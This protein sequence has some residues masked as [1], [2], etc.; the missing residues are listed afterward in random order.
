MSDKSQ[1]FYLPELDI[2]RCLA[3][4]AVFLFHAFRTRFVDY[5]AI[6]APFA[7][8]IAAVLDTGK[9]SVDLFFTLSAYLITELLIREQ[10]K[11]GEIDAK[12]FYLRRMLRIFPLYY[13]FIIFAIFVY[14]LFVPDA[15]IGKRHS[16]GLLTYTFN[17]IV[18][19]FG[20]PP[21]T[22]INHLWS[23]GVEEQFYLAFPFIVKLIGIKNLKYMALIF[24]CVGTVS[25]IIMINTDFF[26]SAEQAMWTSTLTR[27]DALAGGIL[28]AF[29][30]QEKKLFPLTGL[31]SK[32]AVIFFSITALALC[33]SYF[34]VESNVYNA[35][36]VYPA[37]TLAGVVIIWAAISPNLDFSKFSVLIY[38]GKISYG[39]YVFHLFGLMLAKNIL[40][41]SLKNNSS[42]VSIAVLGFALTLIF[43]IASYHL[44][45]K[46]FLKLKKR[47]TYVS[48]R[49]V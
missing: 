44:L 29:Y 49:P 25:R 2:V 17:W 43:A 21:R 41:V 42:A 27:L 38:L 13:V 12:S 31:F 34:S 24:L 16:L 7:G 48:S 28:L 10:K 26:V 45:E 47:F 11:N 8:I 23:V 19:I 39:L 5:Q 40:G 1:K 36:L 9:Y 30:L 6:P 32:L 14:P 20:Y 3:F 15:A 35:L 33:S 22:F 18:S 4:F 46:P 37:A